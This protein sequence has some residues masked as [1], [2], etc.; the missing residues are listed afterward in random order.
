M[1]A[2]SLLCSPTEAALAEQKSLGVRHK[3]LRKFATLCVRR[4]GGPHHSLMIANA[5]ADE[6]LV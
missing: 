1:T 5:N 4:R 3:R 6:P 2:P